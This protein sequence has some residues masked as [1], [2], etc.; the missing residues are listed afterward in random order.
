M[1]VE[2]F[3]SRDF[4]RHLHTLFRVAS[5]SDYELKLVEVTDSSNTYLEQ[6]SLF[7]TGASSSWLQQ[8][9]YTLMHP[10]ITN[11]ELFLVPLGSDAEGMRYEAAFSRFIHTSNTAVSS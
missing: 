9:M 11:C 4:A 6:F 2:S 10:H 5:T 1:S 3:T 8:G 7:F